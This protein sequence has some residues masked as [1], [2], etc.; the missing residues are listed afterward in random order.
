MRGAEAT[1]SVSRG[2]EITVSFAFSSCSLFV[3]TISGPASLVTAPASFA[4]E[5]DVF[6]FSPQ[7]VQKLELIT[8]EPHFMHFVDSIS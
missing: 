1:V 2:A 7:F 4:G 6:S 3:T 5:P 8:S